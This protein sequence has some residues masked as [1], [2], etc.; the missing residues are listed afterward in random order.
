MS[1]TD[2]FLLLL[3]LLPL[4]PSAVAPVLVFGPIFGGE[5]FLLLLL[6]LVAVAVA[7]LFS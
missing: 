7:V 6:L 2:G 5:A 4:P 1:G 3:L